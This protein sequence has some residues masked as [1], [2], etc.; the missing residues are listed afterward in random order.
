MSYNSVPQE[1]QAIFDIKAFKTHDSM[2]TTTI[3]Y[4]HRLS[5][6]LVSAEQSVS[7]E[8][9]AYVYTHAVQCFLRT[10]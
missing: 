3:H 8:F 6:L 7:S 5:S 9:P 1:C 4:S 10:S 2:A